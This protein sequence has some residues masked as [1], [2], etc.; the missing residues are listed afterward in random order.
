MKNMMLEHLYLVQPKIFPSADATSRASGAV[1]ILSAAKVCD[2]L[3]DAVA[4][5]SIVIGASARHRTISW[6]LLTPRVCAEKLA[7][8]AR[9][10]QVAL[11]FGRENSGLKNS[12][13]DQC[14]YL[15]NIPCNLEFSSLNLAAA[16]QVI[17]YE[18]FMASG[19]SE[20]VDSEREDP[21]AT[22]RQMESFYQHLEQTMTDIGFMHPDKSRSIM[23]RLRRVYNRAEL[24][25]KELD[26]LRG[27]LKMSQGNKK[28][29]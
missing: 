14:Q 25:G 12:E 19:L 1:D 21:L 28:T 2:S 29:G 20:D 7:T 5:C 23:R 18:L 3:Q 6:P 10:Q 24:D 22:G 15:L 11:V 16:V 17:S 27:I 9:K 8:E 26:I 13:L 4:D